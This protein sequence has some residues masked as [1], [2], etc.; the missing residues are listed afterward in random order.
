[1]I[2]LV[3]ICQTQFEQSEIPITA[4]PLQLPTIHQAMV[5]EILIVKGRKNEMM[6][7]CI[8]ILGTLV[9]AVIIFFAVFP[10]SI[11]NIGISNIPLIWQ[12]A[13]LFYGITLISFFILSRIWFNYFIFWRYFFWVYLIISIIVIFTTAESTP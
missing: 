12:T 1:M 6:K 9:F 5:K 10:E 13:I 3:L 11:F 2:I 7:N 8:K 4:I